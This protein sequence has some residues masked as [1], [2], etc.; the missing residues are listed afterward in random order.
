MKKKA[1]ISKR[2]DTL[3]RTF[4]QIQK[5]LAQAACNH[6]RLEIVIDAHGD[7]ETYAACSI[8]GRILSSTGLLG[9]SG[10][11]K[12]IKKVFQNFTPTRLQD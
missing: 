11:K 4:V 5:R 7:V 2:L 6:E 12:Q 3:E 9:G 10:L 8:C 1:T